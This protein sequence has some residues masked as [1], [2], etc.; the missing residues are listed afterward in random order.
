MM[1]R[2]V[3]QLPE[4]ARPDHPIL[5]YELGRSGR[6]P[7]RRQYLRTA[8]FAALIVLLYWGGYA[9]AT[10]FFQNP[11]GQ[12]LTEGA[13]A[14]VMW[15]TLALQVLMQVAALALTVNT[16]SE[17]KRRQTWD[18]LRATEGGVSLAFRTRWA[19]V[20]Y[21]LRPL[22]AVVLI[23]RVLLIVGILIDLTAFQGRY[24]DL[25]INGIV[26]D[27]SPV[28]GALLLA[29]L[30]TA[31][32]L[33]PLTSV[34]LEAAIGLLVSVT[35]QQ[36]LYSVMAQV[37]VIAVR[38]LL[39]IGLTVA[40]TQFIRGELTSVNDGG[41]WLLMGA[42][43]AFGDW[44]LSFLHLGFYSEI[45]ATIPFGILLGIGLLIF[46]MAQSALTE[47]I[48]ALAIRRAERTG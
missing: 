28:V 6:L 30:M 32:L 17:Q 44:G 36:R 27:I 13:I 1:Q 24:I 31:S 14:V 34:G 16:V 41:A 29:F 5:R 25:L 19:T 11:P 10:G 35:L 47:W 22:L 38:L 23:I 8:G 7:R 33:L 21:R 4:W 18:N 3:T 37:I 39:V 45:W 12:N 2:F 48:L 15:P 20:F 26:P 46:S 40:A 43:A 42:F 9:Y